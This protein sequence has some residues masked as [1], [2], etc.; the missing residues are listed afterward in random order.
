LKVLANG[1]VGLPKFV[2][3]VQ[4]FF[5]KSKEGFVWEENCSLIDLVHG[6]QECSKV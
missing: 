5:I 6:S 4:H 3:I 2:R 1:S